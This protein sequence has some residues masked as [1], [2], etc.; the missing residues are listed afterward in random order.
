M[1]KEWVGP[2]Q[3]ESWLRLLQKYAFA[4]VVPCVSAALRWTNW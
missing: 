3:K 2:D 4:Q 1:E